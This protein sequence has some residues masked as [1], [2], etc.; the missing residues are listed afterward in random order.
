MTTAVA[1]NL[2]AGQGSWSPRHRSAR[3][4]NHVAAVPAVSGPGTAPSMEENATGRGE[5]HV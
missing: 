4:A 5:P 1:P 2:N 3:D